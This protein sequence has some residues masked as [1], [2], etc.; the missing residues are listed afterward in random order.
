MS[1]PVRL[2]VTAYVMISMGGLLIHLKLHP[3]GQGFYFW[4]AAPVAVFSLVVIPILFCRSST[5]AWGYMLNA[6]VV[7]T[8]V[9]GMGYFS[10]I[11]AEGPVSLSFLLLKT[12]F[13]DIL[14]LLA[15]LP[16]AHAILLQVRPR[17][18]G[19]AERG[20]R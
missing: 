16:I 12:T 1:K 5:V 13:P 10:F 7:L 17:K 6:A 15:K 11:K 8:G 19:G 9:V 20:C 2:L 18:P 14:I 3:P 4:L